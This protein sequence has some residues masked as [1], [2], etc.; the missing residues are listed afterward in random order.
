MA[1]HEIAFRT[2]AS[3]P[4]MARL[5]IGTPLAEVLFEDPN[6]FWGEAV[7]SPEHPDVL[8][9]WLI[10]PIVPEDVPHEQLEKVV[11]SQLSKYVFVA[12]AKFPK[13]HRFFG[14]GMP[15]GQ[16]RRLSRMYVFGQRNAWSAKMQQEAEELSARE[17]IFNNIEKTVYVARRAI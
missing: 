4:R 8:Y 10:Y 16:S 13:A 5:L 15:N 17:D 11:L 1:A 7:E 14:I 9:V 6:S 3:E 2:L 12:M